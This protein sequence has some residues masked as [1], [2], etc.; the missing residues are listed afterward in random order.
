MEPQFYAELVRLTG[1][2]DDGPLPDQ[3]D[4]QQWPAMK[5]RL[6][7]IFRSKTRAQWQ[8]IMEGSDVC[9]AP[10]LSMAEAPDHP[11]ARHRQAFVEVGG[12]T[13]PGPAPR[14]SRTPGA[15]QGAPVHPGEHT[16]EIGALRDEGAVA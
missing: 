6:A 11:H 16:D 12:V 1:L 4:E 8:E 15:V 3:L 14:F 2:G 5:D 9:F 13:Q 10:V 7:A